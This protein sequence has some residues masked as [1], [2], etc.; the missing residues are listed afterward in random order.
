[1]KK[2]HIIL[3]AM[4]MILCSVSASE[5]KYRIR[6]QWLPQTQFAGYYMAAEKGFYQADGVDVEIF[7]V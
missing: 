3:M 5:A 6:L 4:A 7:V 2:T 1:M